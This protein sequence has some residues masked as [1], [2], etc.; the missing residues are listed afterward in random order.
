MFGSGPSTLPPSPTPSRRTDIARQEAAAAFKPEQ[1][2]SGPVN[3][4]LRGQRAEKLADRGPTSL[5]FQKREA[6]GKDDVRAQD[7]SPL[8]SI[9]K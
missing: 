2:R 4:R 8:S 9:M 3:R 7:R 5:T 1:L 6:E